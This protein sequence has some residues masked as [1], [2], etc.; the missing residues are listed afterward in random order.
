MYEVV[1][2][3]ASAER[4]V[5]HTKYGDILPANR[6]LSG[7]EIELIHSQDREHLLQFALSPL[8]NRYDYILIDTPPTLTLLTLQCLCACDSVLI[9]VQCEYYAL[10]GLSDLIYT[11]RQVRQVLQ[12][13]LEIEGILLT[14][15]DSRL[16]LSLQV[17]QEV[18][19]HFQKE[20]Y[21][22][23]IPRNVRLSEAPSHGMP[24]QYYDKISKGSE[25]YEQLALEILKHNQGW[26][27]GG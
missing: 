13:N 21:A 19:R 22:T 4:A 5:I 6:S 3:Q 12:P 7:A 11:I 26:A 15:Y 17:A 27:N 14:M 25:T 18:K 20:L 10:E 1:I 2:S 16:N 23:V 9:P 8:R 24:V